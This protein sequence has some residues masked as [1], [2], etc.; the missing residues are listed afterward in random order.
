M[1]ILHT[2]SCIPPTMQLIEEKLELKLEKFDK[3]EASLRKI[4]L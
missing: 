4:R 2:H 3:G 1:Q